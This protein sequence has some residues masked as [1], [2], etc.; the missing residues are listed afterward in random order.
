MTSAVPP[1]TRGTL[2]RVT[3]L[4]GQL[5]LGGAERQL[6]LLALELRRRGIGVHVLLLARGGPHE[7]AL[8]D[9]GV[10]VHHL[11]FTR[12]GRLAPARNVLAF[13]RMVRLLRRVRPQVLHAY[14]PESYLLGVPAARLAQ[15]PVVIAGRRGL[16]RFNKARTPLFAIGTVVTRLADHVVANAAAVAED[17]RRAERIPGHKLTVIYNGLSRSA[18][19]RVDPAPLGTGLPVVLCVARLVPE[20]GL[21]FLV[22]AAAILARRG[23]P[24]TVALA[25][26]GPARDDLEAHARALAVDLRLLGAQAD[27]R[28]LLAAADVVV[29]PSLAEGMSNAIMEAM[30]AGRPVVATDVGG[31]A[32]LLED[33]GILVPPEDPVALGEGILRVLDDPEL[34]ARLGTEARAWA[35]KNL[36]LDVMADDH[37]ALYRRLL[38]E[39]CGG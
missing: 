7:A 36:D 19:D 33:R 8:R 18:F 25:G 26:D 39:R 28:P 24:C 34:A 21:G 27:V 10:E 37:L 9:A 12:S 3:F 14:L 22:D 15:V 11:G 23:R 32:E 1:G 13:C 16:S 4:I 35:R 38:D 6:S 29:L 20:K 2:K 5:G 31:A 30:A 17:A